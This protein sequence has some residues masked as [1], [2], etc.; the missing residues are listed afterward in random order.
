MGICIHMSI[1][2][3][4]KRQEWETV[5]EESLQLVKAFSLAERRTVKCQGIETMCLVP[6]KERKE[7]F[8]WNYEK[9]R[10][11]WHASGDYETLHGAEDYFL[12]R[13]LCKVDDENPDAGDALLGVL[14][15]YMSYNGDD[16]RYDQVYDLWGAKTQGEPYHIYLLAIACLIESRLGEKAFV[17]G[18]ITRGQ[19][20]KAVELA[21]EHLKVAIDIPA[22]CDMERLQ[23]RVSKL[24]LSEE[25]QL[26][27][28]ERFYLGTKSAEFGEFI[29]NRYS[30][31]SC[32][33][34][35]KERFE[36]SIINTLGFEREAKNYLLWGFDLR[37]LCSLVNYYDKENTAQ[38]ETFVKMIMDAK[39]HQ[40]V[41]NCDDI[42]DIDQEE[43]RPYGID[44]LMARF[45]YAGARNR[46]VDR[47]I[48]IEEIRKALKEGLDNKCD[49]DFIIDNYLT[50]EAEAKMLDSYGDK[51]S[52]DDIMKAYEQDAAEVFHRAMNIK[53]DVMEE[54]FGQYDISDSEELIYYKDG[55]TIQPYLKE[56]VKKSY[57]FYTS[58][59]SEDSYN[60]LINMEP[61]SRCRWLVEQNRSILIR[62][63]DWNKIFTDIKK[64][65]N[66]FSRYYPM[67]RVELSSKQLNYMVIAFVLNDELYSYCKKLLEEGE[68]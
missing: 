13:D 63:K 61:E 52:E 18:D 14:P 11:G 10:T 20:R 15:A 6:T 9:V 31:D 25:E 19:C 26:A 38:Y 29:R 32:N 12:P 42:L 33:K 51:I 8:G 64:H 23:E 2:K 49:L 46:K 44:F 66:A 67:M 43:S 27:I 7:K 1:S 58:I 56:S 21:N 3:S 35:W 47:Y 45:V 54:V 24:P 48:P 5:Y 55:D 17:Y 59:L 53:K 57:A 37:N 28:F 30:E 22:R 40:K 4:V 50:K 62:D 65:K 41:K 34:Y 39:L 60:E 68:S 16:P 36:H